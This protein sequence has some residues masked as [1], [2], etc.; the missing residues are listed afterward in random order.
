MLRLQASVSRYNV[1][2]QGPEVELG[3]SRWGSMRKAWPTK[4]LRA[5]RRT[6]GAQGPEHLGANCDNRG[7]QVWGTEQTEK[8]LQA[9]GKL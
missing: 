6:R 7:Q 8:G 4:V 1:G 5:F 2:V 9:S 3:M